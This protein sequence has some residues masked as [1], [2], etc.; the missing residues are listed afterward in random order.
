MYTI[1]EQPW[2]AATLS[3]FGQLN[4]FPSI[5]TLIKNGK[6]RTLQ[7]IELESG[8]GHQ[9]RLW[10]WASYCASEVGDD[11][12]INTFMKNEQE[13]LLVIFDCFIAQFAQLQSPLYIGI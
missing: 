1:V 11:D 10:K 13:I 6:N 12:N 8:I 4:Q 2:R 3:P 9:W 5:Q 7:A